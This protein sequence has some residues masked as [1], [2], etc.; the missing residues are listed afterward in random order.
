M[1]SH[2]HSWIGNLASIFSENDLLDTALH[3]VALNQA[4]AKYDSDKTFT[5]MEEISYKVLDPLGNGE[6][7][8]LRQLI[9]RAFEEY[10]T[11]VAIPVEM[12]V[13]IG[14]KAV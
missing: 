4:Y 14:R 6:G 11:G 13:A 1:Y 12:V 2:H 5:S 7:H 8:H 9:G 10:Q 3:R